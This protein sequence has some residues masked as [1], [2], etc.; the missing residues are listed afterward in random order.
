MIPAVPPGLGSGKQLL[1]N[2]QNEQ[3]HLLLGIPGAS[4]TDPDY[5]AMLILN[6]ILGETGRGGRIGNLLK[7]KEGMAFYA[8]SR[9]DGGMAGGPFYLSAGVNAQDVDRALELILSELERIRTQG[10]S[11]EEYERARLSLVY[12]LPLELESNEGIA[13]KLI[14][15]EIFQLGS[16]YLSRYAGFLEEVSFEKLMDCWRTRLAFDKAAIVIAGPYQEKGR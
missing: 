14:E 8:Q 1:T 2:T 5:Y 15:M 3:C 4:I 13:R 12:R 7:N 9:L 16:D 6:Q 10:I 11:R